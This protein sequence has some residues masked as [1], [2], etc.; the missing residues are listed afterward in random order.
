MSMIKLVRVLTGTAV[1]AGTVLAIK[2]LGDKLEDMEKQAREDAQKKFDD[3]QGEDVAKKSKVSEHE[4]TNDVEKEENEKLQ[5]K[6]IDI[7]EAQSISKVKKLV[8]DNKLTETNTAVS[9]KPVK[10]TAKAKAPA[11][12]KAVATKNVTSENKPKRVR[13]SKPKEVESKE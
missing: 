4:N 10:A 11:V 6:V 7:K 3:E 9:V 5:K 1:I 13:A 8:E 2:A 12:K